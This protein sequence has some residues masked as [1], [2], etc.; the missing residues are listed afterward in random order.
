MSVRPLALVAF[1]LLP[2]LATGW[3]GTPGAGTQVQPFVGSMP[4]LVVRCHASDESAE[5]Q[6]TAYFKQLFTGAGK[7]R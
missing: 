7:A 3:S 2:M 6:S 4:W 5:P 1:A